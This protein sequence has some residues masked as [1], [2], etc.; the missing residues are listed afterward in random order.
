MRSK[1]RSESSIV[2]WRGRGSESRPTTHTLGR[3]V[4]RGRQRYLRSW[5]SRTSAMTTMMR[6]RLWPRTLLGSVPCALSLS[7]LGAL[8]GPSPTEA[9]PFAY[10]SGPLPGIVVVDTVTDGVVATVAA[11]GGGIAIPPEGPRAYA[12]SGKNAVVVIDPAS[13]PVIATVTVPAGIR[14]DGNIAITPNGT[15]AYVAGP[16]IGGPSTVSV[17]DTDPS[18]S[19]YNAVVATVT[20]GNTPFGVAVTPD[21]AFAYVTNSRDSN[22][23]RGTGVSVI[24]TASNTVVATV[25]L[26]PAGHTGARGIAISPDGT[27]AYVVDAGLQVLWVLDTVTNT[28]ITSITVGNDPVGVALTPDGAFAYVTNRNAGLS[29]GT[30]S[31]LNTTTNTVAATVDSLIASPQ[32]PAMTPDGTRVYLS[33]QRETPPNGKNLLVLDTTTNTVVDTITAGQGGASWLAFTPATTPVTADLSIKKTA[34]PLVAVRG[35]S[36]S[37][38]LAASNAGSDTATSVGVTDT[39]PAGTTF[40]GVSTN[41]GTC[42]SPPFGSA[43]TVS[44]NLGSMPSGSKATITLNVNVTAAA[45]GTIANIASVTSLTSDPNPANNSATVTTNVVT[46]GSISGVV[47]SGGLPVGAVRVNAAPISPGGTFGTATTDN[48]TGPAVIGSPATGVYTISGLAPGSY[49][50]QAQADT[51]ATQWWNGKATFGTADIVTVTGGATTSNI[52]FNLAGGPGT[53]SAGGISG[54]VTQTNG[55]TPIPFAGVSV[56]LP[57]GDFVLDTNANENGAYNTGLRLTPG[58][59]KVRASASGF[60]ARWYIGASNVGAATLV[61]VVGGQSTAPVNFALPSGGGIVGRVTDGAGHGV[62]GANVSFLDAA[63]NGF[64]GGAATLSDGTYSANRQLAPG[65][66]KVEASASGFVSTFSGNAHNINTA[67]S[68]IV[69]SGQDATVNIALTAGQ[70]ISGFVTKTDSLGAPLGVAAGAAVGMVEATTG[71]FVE[72]GLIADSTGSYSTQGTLPPGRYKVRAKLAGFITTYWNGKRTINTADAVDV[73]TGNATSI[74]I[75]LSQGGRTISGQITQANSTPTMFLQG[76]FVNAFDFATGAY[77]DTVQ[78]DSNGNYT[79]NGT[80]A[81][82]TYKVQ[83]GLSGVATIFFHSR[84]SFNLADKIDVTSLNFT[85]A[86][87]ALPVAGGITGTIRDTA[88]NP[89]AR[90]IVDVADATTNT[91]VAGGVITASDGTYST[92]RVLAAGPYT[93]KARLTGFSDT[94]YAVAPV[95]GLD[96]FSATAVTV[97][98]SADTPGVDVALPPGGTIS[99]TIRDRISGLAIGGASVFAQR[100]ASSSFFGNFFVSTDSGGNFAIAGLR[101]GQWLITAVASGHMA[102]WFSGDPDNPATDFGTSTPIRISGANTFSTANINLQAGGGGIQ[103][104]VTRSDNGQ[105]VPTGTAVLVRG[106][107]PRTGNPVSLDARTD[108]LGNYS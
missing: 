98:G 76:A 6:K 68:V 58:S 27:R 8:M 92:G 70:T 101:D 73:T 56:T 20:V 57:S 75:A 99:G 106:P 97:A 90:A 28:L 21:G 42:T 59:Y 4:N 48:L 11:G 19:T 65:S 102:A 88:G 22:V 51:F 94:F 91:L 2:A 26:P 108:D 12:G 34:N 33:C 31:V 5:P 104:R 61:T 81:P 7:L 39:L 95:L 32:A 83:A 107:F 17:I 89:L 100:V 50:V 18:S 1:R 96:F 93:V 47:R 46:G 77:V 30:I 23:S 53:N 105:P 10:V 103:G 13:N 67:A 41:S 14:G 24:N 3:Q 55:T 87:I 63:T 25:T 36:L 15:R 78:S 66:Y 69:N 74:N 72:G 37:Y 60:G 43:G 52:D 16:E 35:G 85:S 82:G 71:A 44:C 49:R 40:S 29:S 38:T 62:A 80:L 86:N 79:F 84:L 9:R 45:S 64:V 54:Q